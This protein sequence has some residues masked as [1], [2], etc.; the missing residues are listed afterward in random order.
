[1]IFKIYFG[2]PDVDRLMTELNS[3]RKSG[4]ISKGEIKFHNKLGKTFL[5]L[6]QNPQHN[7][8]ESHEIEDLTR[9]FG[10]KVFQS[11]LE[12]KTPAAGRVFWAYGPKKNNITILAIQKHPDKNKRGSYKRI[13]LSDFSDK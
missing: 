6:S 7:S 11:Y 5:L 4:K 8:L 1:M 13:K 2:Y 3:K 10:K 12:N 9:K